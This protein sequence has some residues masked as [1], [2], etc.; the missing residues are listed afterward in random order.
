[1]LVDAV[2][3][4]ALQGCCSDSRRSMLRVRFLKRKPKI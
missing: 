3:A 1:M 4:N 2:A